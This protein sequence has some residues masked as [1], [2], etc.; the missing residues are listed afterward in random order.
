MPLEESI[1]NCFIGSKLVQSC[2]LFVYTRKTGLKPVSSLTARQIKL[3]SLRIGLDSLVD[4]TICFH[5]EQT[6]L[7]RYRYSQRK[8][9]NTFS[10]HM[11]KV[12][13]VLW[14]ITFEV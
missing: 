2:H 10:K 3:I 9:C 5:H 13:T 6:V 1:D 12:K 4:K 8:C 7:S 11:K 14:E